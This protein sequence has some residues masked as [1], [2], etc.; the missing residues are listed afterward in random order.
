MFEF[1]F[2]NITASPMLAGRLVYAE[3]DYAFNFELD[4]SDEARR[5]TRGSTSFVIGTLQLEVALESMQCLYI[6][7]YCPQQGWK[8]SPLSPPSA[9]QGSL[10]VHSDAPLTAGV[11]I[12]LDKIM[13]STP[14]FDPESGWFCI[15]NKEV[16]ADSQAVEFANNCIAVIASGQL[17]SLWIHPENWKELAQH[18]EGQRKVTHGPLATSI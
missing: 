2:E 7:G 14:W 16:D 9:Q 10:K 17:S 1:S 11:S 6:W 15:G 12:G 18:F 3:S 8:L 13:P 5:G 4:P